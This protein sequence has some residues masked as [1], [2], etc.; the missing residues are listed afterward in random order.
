MLAEVEGANAFDIRSA[1]TAKDVWPG[2]FEIPQT[3]AKG[4]LAFMNG[5]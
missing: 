3:I 4:A 1:L 2:F 5:R